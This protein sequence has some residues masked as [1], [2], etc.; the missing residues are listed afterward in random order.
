MEYKCLPIGITYYLSFSGCYL[1][2]KLPLLKTQVIE[3]SQAYKVSVDALDVEIYTDPLQVN[4]TIP[5]EVPGNNAGKYRSLV[6]GPDGTA[7]Y[8]EVISVGNV[9]FFGNLGVLAQ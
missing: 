4:R 2:E 5:V 1:T 9:S 8:S 3:S 7:T 6:A